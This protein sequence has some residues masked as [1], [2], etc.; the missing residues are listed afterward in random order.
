MPDPLDVSWLTQQMQ[1]DLSQA[2][3]KRDQLKVTRLLAA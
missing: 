1:Y 3:K 2:D